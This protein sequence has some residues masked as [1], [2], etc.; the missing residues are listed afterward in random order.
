VPRAPIRIHV[1]A[2]APADGASTSVYAACGFTPPS[3]KTAPVWENWV[4]LDGPQI[5]AVSDSETLP[6]YG[7]RVPDGAALCLVNRSK[8]KTSFRI[9]LRLPRGVYTVE[10]FIFSPD[11]PETL[12]RI[13]RLESVTPGGTGTTSRPGWLNP[14]A[15]AIYRFFNRSAQTFGAFKRVK[16]SV[17]AL[18]PARPGA[19]R[20]LMTPLRECEAHVG[21]LSIGKRRGRR[22]DPLKHIHR[23][24]LTVA[25][26]QALCRNFRGQG[27]LSRKEEDTLK[28]ALDRLEEALTEMSVGCLNLVPGLAVTPP[29]PA[30]PNVR[31]VTVSVT[32]AG[33][34]SVSFVKLGASVAEGATIWPAEQAPFGALRP[35]ETVRA[36]FTIRLEDEAALRDLTAD[37][38]YFAARVPAHLRLKG[39]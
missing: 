24:L 5:A 31:E 22:F 27:R 14:G 7:V 3:E 37:I 4:S 18:R 32:N 16:E 21:A 19:F 13:E 12:P 9:D 28:T 29:D 30:R 35:G 20:L 33:R 36:T 26:A 1:D 11:A 25:H 8:T 17:R 6:V 10:R 23:A 34:Q 2:L 38:A 39:I 15:A